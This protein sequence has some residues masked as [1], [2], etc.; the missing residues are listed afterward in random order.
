MQVISNLL[1]CAP[2]FR[3]ARKHLIWKKPHV[4]HTEAVRIS[5]LPSHAESVFGTESIGCADDIVYISSKM[6]RNTEVK[7][8][9][10]NIRMKA[11]LLKARKTEAE[12]VKYIIFQDPI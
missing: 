2:I 9:G 6:D 10:M 8:L 11:A 4:F 1:V 12:Q 3:S 5:N 7:A